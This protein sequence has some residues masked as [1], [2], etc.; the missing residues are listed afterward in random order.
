M[1]KADILGKWTQQYGT[2]FIKTNDWLDALY[3]D[4]TH[5]KTGTEAYK[6]HGHGAERPKP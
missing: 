2:G 1:K 4:V 6:P 5:A 3:D